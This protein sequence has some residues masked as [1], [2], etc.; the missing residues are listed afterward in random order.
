[1]KN[2]KVEYWKE[3]RYVIVDE[4]SGKI[5]DDAQGYGYKDKQK[6]AELHRR[7]STKDFRVYVLAAASVPAQSLPVLCLHQSHVPHIWQPH[8]QLSDFW[9]NRKREILK[10][11]QNRT[12]MCATCP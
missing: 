11:F 1:M 5:I 2:P 12:F 9:Q 8:K 7:L 10:K 3:G 4:D 6:E